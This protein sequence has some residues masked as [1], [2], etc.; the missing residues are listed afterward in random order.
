MIDRDLA[1]AFQIDGSSHVYVRDYIEGDFPLRILQHWCSRTTDV[2]VALPEGWR[3]RF[4][5]KVVTD[6]TGKRQR[7]PVLLVECEHLP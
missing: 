1:P 4:A 5:V 2:T 6:Q 7:F 3:V